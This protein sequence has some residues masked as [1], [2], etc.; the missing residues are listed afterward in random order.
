MKIR[1]SDIKVKN[2][3]R[4]DRG[5]ISALKE[6]I[7]RIGL[8]HPIII[9]LDN[10]LIAGERRLE[11]VKE[12]GWEHV[13]VKVVDVKNKKDRILIEA[14]ENTSRLDFT[15]EELQRSK[16]LIERYSKTN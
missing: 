8:L 3:I 1:V 5:D 15:N 9:D 10:K 16:E 11:A 7:H 14:D 13:E 6:S 2:R 4:L 12:L